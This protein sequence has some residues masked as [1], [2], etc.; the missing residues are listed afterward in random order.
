MNTKLGFVVWTYALIVA[1]VIGFNM[2]F[3]NEPIPL[4]DCHSASIKWYNDRPMCIE[5]LM[6]G[7]SHKKH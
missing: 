3:I 2:S 1:L 4:S 5:F 7:I 6:V